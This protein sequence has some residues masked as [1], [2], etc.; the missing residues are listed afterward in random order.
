VIPRAV[1]PPLLMHSDTT[2]LQLWKPLQSRDLA[3]ML[4]K[5]GTGSEVPN[6]DKL[7]PL[8]ELSCHF[9]EPLVARM[10]HLVVQL[11]GEYPPPRQCAS[12]LKA[13]RHACFRPGKGASR[14]ATRSI[15]RSVLFGR[16]TKLALGHRA[17]W[18]THLRGS[19]S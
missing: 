18:R 10:I 11:P 9:S 6:A 13:T 17:R 3:K 7:D 8:E 14:I 15:S 1:Y 16:E 12:P 5:I 4:G 2:R 19:E